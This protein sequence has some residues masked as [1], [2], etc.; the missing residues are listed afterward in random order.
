MPKLITTLRSILL[1]LAIAPLVALA[2]DRGEAFALMLQQYHELGQFNGVALVADGD[3]TVLRKGFGYADFAGRTDNGPELRFLV[4]SISKSV[5]ALIALQLERDGELDLDATVSE[6]LPKYRKDTGAKLTLRHLLAHT[7]GLPNYTWDSA[8]WQPWEEDKPLSTAEFVER[9]CSGDLDFEP[10]SDYRYGNSGY[11]ILGAIIESVTGAS[12]AEVVNQRVIEPFGLKDSGVYRNETGLDRRAAGHEIS[13]DGFRPALP[14]YKPLFAAG[15]MFWTADDLRTYNSALADESL[16][17]ESIRQELFE[18]RSGAVDGTFAYGWNVGQT[19]LRGSIKPTRYMATNGEINGFNAMLLRI[20]ADD[21]L[22]VLLNNTG[23]TNLP[24]IASS[25]MQVLYGLRP[26]PPTPKIRDVFLQKLRDE[27]QSA[28]T[29]YYRRQRDQ[30]PDDFLYMP[31]PLRILAGQ[32][33]DE[34]RYDE[35]RLLLELN[36]ETNPADQRSIQMLSGIDS[37]GPAK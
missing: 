16:V 18:I 23:E 31:W 33:I 36:L 19:D 34:A 30:N 5:T 26:A 25:V 4:G 13:V 14:V 2:D 10:G 37:E 20:P 15:S 7:D 12:F 35:A 11:S 21:R 22:I 24:E 1:L 29:A 6:Y 17:P 8:F 32:L 3:T 9:Y 27:S 28:A